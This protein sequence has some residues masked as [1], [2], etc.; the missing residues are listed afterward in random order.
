MFR[1][2]D[3]AAIALFLL[4]MA[5]IGFYFGKRNTGTEAYFFGNRA[6]PGWV[7]GLSML[8]TSISSVTFLALPA[9]AYAL[10]YRQSVTNLMMPIAAVFAMIFL[11]PLF[12]RGHAST[13]FEYLEK[14]FGAV[15]RSYG[16]ASFVILQLIRLATVL[17]LVSLPLAAMTDIPL[18]WVIIVSGFFI[19]LY[20]VIG[21]IEAVIWT[22]VIQTIILLLGG[23]LCLILILFALPNGLSDV[24][25]IGTEFNKFSFGPATWGFGDRTLTVVLLLGLIHFGTEYAGNQNVIQRYLAAKSTREAR[26]ATLLCA[27]MSVPTWMMFFFLGTSLFVF[28]TLFSAALPAG[29][30]ADQVLP[31]FILTQL[32]SGVSG[33]VIA[34]CLAAAMSSLDSSV[35][36]IS[37][38]VTVD[39]IKRYGRPRSDAQLLNIAKRIAIAAGIVMIA[40]AIVVGHIEKESVNDLTLILGSMFGGGMFAVY[41]TGFLMRRVSSRAMI[42]AL[43]AGLLVNIWLGLNTLG[44]LPSMLRADIHAYW[45][46]IAVNFLVIALS[47]CL[48]FLFPEK[49]S[50]A[51][52]TIQTR[53]EPESGL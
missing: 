25:R 47:F 46:T 37:T 36:A 17:Y 6:F 45:T 24:I 29:L 31:H 23:L 34:A 22:D 30:P 11:I 7:L 15:M 26:K 38:V 14:R 2:L 3:I 43:S 4:V 8:G 33:I 5:G 48:G 21:G 42:T 1:P 49:R 40:G 44:W 27:V 18:E 13:A 16:A 53:H 19:G 35:N 20:T 52:L 10:D 32:P 28:Y 9:A 12:R 51:G 50:L 39:F 41:M